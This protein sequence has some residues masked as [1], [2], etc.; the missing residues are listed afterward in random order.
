MKTIE[1]MTYEEL[2][3]EIKYTVSL[4]D[5][6]AQAQHSAAYLADLTEAFAKKVIEL[7]KSAETPGMGVRRSSPTGAD[8]GRRERNYIRTARE[9]AYLYG[10]RYF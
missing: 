10:H 5:D 4:M 7:W 9:R 3:K 2:K 8:D 1:E 6:D